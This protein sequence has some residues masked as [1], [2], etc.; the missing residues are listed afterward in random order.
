MIMEKR[1][2]GLGLGAGLIAGIASF[3]YARQ[4]VAP[5]I[6]AA[7]E[8]EEG[9]S[10]A[11]SALTGEHGHEHE[12]FTRGIQENLGAAMGTVGFAVVTGA[13]FAVALVVV[14]T[15]M[16]R[17]RRDID[18]R[19]SA[20][21]L[22]VTAF[23]STAVVP[24]VVYPATLPGIGDPATAGART[25]AYLCLLIASVLLAVGAAVAAY[26][27]SDRIGGWS[28]AVSGVIGYVVLIAI[29]ATVLPVFDETPGP[30]VG[31]DGATIFPGFPAGLLADFRVTAI[32]C[33][34]VLWFTLAAVFVMALPR[35]LRTIGQKT[36]ENEVLRAYR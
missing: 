23:V 3:G 4:Q 17:H 18:P 6:A 26:R 9:R 8:Y 13:L 30:L 29:V 2:I 34:A 12:V 32:I 20:A 7:I 16:R 24:W 14:L 11:E 15:V 33:Q 5:L 27:L 36:T 21:L 19:R 35:V 22:A 25:I 28:A 1:I 10:H 31:A